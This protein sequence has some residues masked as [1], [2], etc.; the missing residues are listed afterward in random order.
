MSISQLIPSLM[1][2]AL[3]RRLANPDVS[4]G[5]LSCDAAALEE[6]IRSRPRGHVRS[7]RGLSKWEDR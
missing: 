4:G 1:I 3:H 5:S 6:V 7:R 2:R